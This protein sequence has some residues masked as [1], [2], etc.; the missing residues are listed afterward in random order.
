MVQSRVFSSSQSVKK[1]LGRFMPLASQFKRTMAQPPQTSY[2]ASHTIASPKTWPVVLATGSGST[3]KMG[4]NFATLS[5]AAN[6]TIRGTSFPNYLFAVFNNMNN[7]TDSN[8]AQLSFMHYGSA[9]EIGIKD[10]T[11]AAILVK[12]DGQYV[13]LS[14]QLAAN[15]GGENFYYL[16]F[17]SADYRK[18][19]VMVSNNLG[20]SAIYT[21]QTDTVT[22]AELRGPRVIVLGD[23]FINTGS[24]AASIN[25]FVQAFA[26]RMGWDDVWPSGLGGTGI[27]TTTSG[28]NYRQRVAQDVI[29]F[30]PDIVIV[31]MSINDAAFT[32][33]QIGTEAAL[34]FAQI[35]TGLPNALICAVS[36]AKTGAAA[37]IS[38]AWAQKDAIKAAVQAAPINGIMLDLMEM[39]LP[40]G[41]MPDTTNTLAAS[42]S[43]NATTLSFT[44]PP[45]LNGTYKFADGTRFVAIGASGTGPYTVTTD[46]GIQT[47]QSNGA[48]IT[49]VGD[50]YLSGSGRVGAPTGQGNCDIMITSD[51]AHPTDAG[52]AH[53]GVTMAMCLIRALNLG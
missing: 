15:T 49:Q 5:K 4:V 43:S 24:S 1:T 26:D 9:I 3:Y 42:A 11:G 13:S 14:P 17:G 44:N 47:G 50:S 53:M 29:A 30:S 28:P 31:Q 46:S 27:L 12:V 37:T 38:N 25:G 21:A 7:G 33:A 23:S 35:R 18:I 34:L 45:A 41:V 2:S 51:G 20:I 32:G 22:P 10:Q 8:A 19:D 39:P 16:N 48:A 36:A 52:H 40:S 6:P